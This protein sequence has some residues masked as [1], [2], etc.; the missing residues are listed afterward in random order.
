M[1][2]EISGARRWSASAFVVGIC[3]YFAGGPNA[4]KLAPRLRLAGGHPPA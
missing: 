3:S 4:E 2:R 1:Q